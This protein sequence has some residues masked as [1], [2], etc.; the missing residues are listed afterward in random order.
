MYADAEDDWFDDM[1]IPLLYSMLYAYVRDPGPPWACDEEAPLEGRGPV[2]LPSLRPDG[3]SVATQPGQ[4][5]LKASLFFFAILEDVK[6]LDLKG[7]WGPGSYG[8]ERALLLAMRWNIL[9]LAKWTDGNGAVCRGSDPLLFAARSGNIDMVRWAVQE[10]LFA[11]YLDRERTGTAKYGAVDEAY[12][13][14]KPEILDF[15][16][17]SIHTEPEI[18]Y[19]VRDLDFSTLE[20]AVKHSDVIFLEKVLVGGNDGINAVRYAGNYLNVAVTN[21][22][23]NHKVDLENAFCAAAGRQAGSALEVIE[24]LDLTQVLLTISSRGLTERF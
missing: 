1:K 18:A 17:E 10:K 24:Y 4:S 13:M 7:H 14:E 9:P 19:I 6:A 8:A 11:T 22:L 2:F 16:F 21:L 23:H 5:S 3:D 20:K 12:Q 15:L